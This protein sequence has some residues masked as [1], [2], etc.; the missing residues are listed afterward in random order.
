[1]AKRGS[2]EQNGSNTVNTGG[3]RFGSSA[4]PGMRYGIFASRIFALA[5]TRRFAIV[6][7]GT[8]N[9][10]A[11]YGVSSP[12]RRRSV[13]AICAVGASAG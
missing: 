4:A 5:R 10:R 7:S 11:M 3:S 1:M 8:R 6:A 13:N 12:P 9:A 2:A